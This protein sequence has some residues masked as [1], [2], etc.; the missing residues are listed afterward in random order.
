MAREGRRVFHQVFGAVDPG[1]FFDLA[2]VT[3]PICTALLY[4]LAS[5]EGQVDLSQ[6]VEDFLDTKTL[7][8]VSLE[9]LLNHTS[10]LV[11]WDSFAKNGFHWDKK[12]NYRKKYEEVIQGILNDKKYLRKRKKFSTCYSDLGYIILGEII[13]KIYGKRLPLLFQE[14]IAKPLGLES[15]IFYVPLD[16][17][18]PF[19]KIEFIPSEIC[20][21][22]KRLI[23]GE[24][25]DRNTYIMGGAT[26]HA[27]LFG[28]AR[29]L[30]KILKE[31]RRAQMGESG[32]ITQASF[33]KFCIPN[34]K[35]KLNS[36]Y[37]T[38]GFD[39]PTKPGS[40]SGKYFSKNT[41]GHLGYS[42]VSFWWDIDKD[43][44][45]ILLSNRCV[46]GR[47]LQKYSQYRPQVYNAL[48][49]KYY[50]DDSS[51]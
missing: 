25:M 44:W 7:K 41:I 31:L 6:S 47:K 42:G 13:E 1:R 12:I 46:F 28:T 15:E 18:P 4:L 36:R 40:L 5:Q 26:G 23:Q 51:G 14:K 50:Y 22:R 29:A 17:K 10:P 39:T 2:S 21:K 33:Q 45:I 27:G 38:L 11:A 8:G 34:P 20:L 9:K 49:K 16:R 19:P 3:K 32:F 35:R 48:M 43:L 24:V 30:H 37:F